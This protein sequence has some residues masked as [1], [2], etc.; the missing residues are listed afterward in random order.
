MTLASGKP[1][2]TNKQNK[3]NHQAE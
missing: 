1:E 2:K 3:P